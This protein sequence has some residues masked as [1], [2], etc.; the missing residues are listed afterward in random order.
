[1][2]IAKIFFTNIAMKQLMI[3]SAGPR[4]HDYGRRTA[5]DGAGLS[6]NLIQSTYTPFF[7]QLRM[8]KKAMMM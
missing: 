5:P 1:M 2:E 3:L 4:S 7:R 8:P 6:R